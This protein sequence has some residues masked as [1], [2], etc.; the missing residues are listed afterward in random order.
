MVKYRLFLFLLAH[1][2]WRFA[3]GQETSF[4]VWN[5]LMYNVP[6]ANV[7]NVEIAPTYSTVLELPKWRCLEVQGTLERAMNK[8]VDLMGALLLGSTFQ[9]EKRSTFEIRETLGARIYLTPNLRLNTRL[10]LRFEQRN[11]Y[12]RELEN[13]ESSHRARIRFETIFP[14]NTHSMNV[15]KDVIYSIAD[16]EGFLVFDEN[17]QERFANRYRIRAGLGYK[18]SNKLRFE[19]IYTQQASRN[20]MDGGHTSNDHIIRFRLKYFLVK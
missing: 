18:V 13:W 5:E 15:E 9:N 4:Q 2:F 16:V 8:H 6:F 10:L 20:T 11:Q 17:L 1:L 12:D 3:N 14:I 7:Y 19:L